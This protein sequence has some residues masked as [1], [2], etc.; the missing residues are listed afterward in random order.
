MPTSTSIIATPTES[1]TATAPRSLS[2][3][4]DLVFK[5]LFSGHLS[6]LTDLINTVRSQAAPIT[7]QR[8]LN[9]GILP[10]DLAGKEIVLDILAEDADGQRLAIEM[11]LQRFQ[12]W[13]QR[14]VY[15]VARSLAAQLR[16]GQDYRLLKPAIGIS[17]L[18]HDLFKEDPDKALWHFALRDAE[19]PQTQLGEVLQVHIIEL[20]K[21]E[22]QR[23]LTEP[24]RAWIACLLHNLDEAAMS[25][26][27]HPPVK[28][29]LKH[30]ETM[31]G[32]EELRLLAERRAQALIDAEDKIDYALHE[33]ERIGLQ[34][35][36]VGTLSTLIT[37]KFDELPDWAA[38]RL[39]QASEADLKRWTL[40][41][42][43][44]QSIEDIFK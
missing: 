1:G 23:G 11:Q 3:S 42:L 13:P 34:K 41:I 33:G 24:L 40:R 9:P 31:Y 19:R 7:V 8:V 12:H 39:E 18:V 5:R 28:E 30:L 6:L 44:A 35:G 26:I 15:G 17:L 37:H 21:A 32:D 22:K 27:T 29:A 14:N 20:N 25:E 2:L 4:N 16:V 43:D 36:A 10:E 38:D